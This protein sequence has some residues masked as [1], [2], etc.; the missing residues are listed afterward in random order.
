MVKSNHMRQF[1]AQKRFILLLSIV[2]LFLLV[3]LASALGNVEFRAGRALGRTESRSIQFSID[4]AAREIADIPFWKHVIFWLLLAVF[5]LLIASLLTPEGR[6]RLLRMFITFVLSFW[7]IYYLWKNNL[8]ELPNI[9]IGAGAGAGPEAIKEP[10][11]LPVFTPPEI[12]GWMNYLISLGVVLALL[13]LA[14]SLN[15]WWQRVKLASASTQTLKDLASV[16]RSSL[17]DLSS[18]AEWA[19]AI[20]N[21]YVRMSDVVGRSRGL[22]R[23]SDMTPAEFAFR[24]ERAG[25]PSDPVRRLTRLFESVRYGAH[26]PAST[27]INEAVSCLNAILRYCGEEV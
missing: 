6:K 17:H 12:P 4:R 11:P 21:C 25:L 5:V 13:V 16:A 15:R 2:S 19:D 3:L 14:W 20:T 8:L 1:F 22:S 23:Q 24:L 7:A 10:P 18:G 26:K 27:E 9:M